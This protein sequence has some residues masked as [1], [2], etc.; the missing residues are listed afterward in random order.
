MFSQFKQLIDA[1]EAK[2]SG[3]DELQASLQASQKEVTRLEQ[4]VQ[5]QQ[6]QLESFSAQDQL[7]SQL[8]RRLAAQSQALEQLEASSQRREKQFEAAQSQAVFLQ[9]EVGQKRKHIQDLESDGNFKVQ[10]I[11]QLHHKLQEYRGIC[12]YVSLHTQV[13]YVLAYSILQAK[14]CS[15]LKTIQSIR[16]SHARCYAMVSHGYQSW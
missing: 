3:F 11:Q 4:L 9:Q 7:V 16:H 2:V 10:K 12:S 14:V 8:T 13:R 6:K 15:D 1:A 5:T